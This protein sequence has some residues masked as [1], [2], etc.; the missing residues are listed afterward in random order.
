M[1]LMLT[2]DLN[3]AIIKDYL[4]LSFDSHTVKSYFYYLTININS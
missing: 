1:L 2:I 4:I 3:Y